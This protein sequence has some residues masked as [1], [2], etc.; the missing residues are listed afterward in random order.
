[1]ICIYLQI[2]CARYISHLR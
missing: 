1:L 2:Q